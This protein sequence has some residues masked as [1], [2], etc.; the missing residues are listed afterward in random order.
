LKEVLDSI[1]NKG[2]SGGWFKCDIHSLRILKPITLNTIGQHVAAL[3]FWE[4]W[5]S[6]VE[7]KFMP[8]NN[9][10]TFV[11]HTHASIYCRHST[12]NINER[13]AMKGTRDETTTYFTISQQHTNRALQVHISL[14]GGGVQLFGRR[15]KMYLELS[16]RP[17]IAPSV[18][19]SNKQ[20][21]DVLWAL[22]KKFLQHPYKR[23]DFFLESSSLY[24]GS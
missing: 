3:Q 7:H 11:I 8:P 5:I 20:A 14:F 23:K 9:E 17:P 21:V 15:L 16:L 19:D 24:I 6:F 1:N 12:D 13:S 18:Y 10:N 2:A 4:E 22:E